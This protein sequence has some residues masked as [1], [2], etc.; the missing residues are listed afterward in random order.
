MTLLILIVDVFLLLA[1]TLFLYL[2]RCLVV[3]M[4]VA[5][6]CTREEMHGIV[7]IGGFA[8]EWCRSGMLELD[9]VNHN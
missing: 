5:V 7:R 1:K 9:T 2:R 3:V 8:V 6:W 4:F